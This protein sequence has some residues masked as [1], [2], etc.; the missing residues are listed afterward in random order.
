MNSGMSRL[1]V[2]LCACASVITDVDAFAPAR[3]LLQPAGRNTLV[4][5]V[6]MAGKGGDE[7][8]YPFEERRAWG[9]AETIATRSPLVT[10][11]ERSPRSSA[12]LHAGKETDVGTSAGRQLLGLKDAGDLKDLPLWKIRLQLTKPATWVPLIWG[13]MCGAAASGNFHWWNP[14]TIGQVR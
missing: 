6:R 5:N 3:P 7:A 1:L 13:V 9:G 14:L 12:V 2:A 11:R 10:G 8:F 4:G